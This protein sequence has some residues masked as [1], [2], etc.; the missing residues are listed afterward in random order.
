MILT[1]ELARLV[2][3]ELQFCLGHHHRR[4]HYV[5]HGHREVSNVILT[6]R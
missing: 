6:I 2:P 5:S 4:A 1:L 3:L